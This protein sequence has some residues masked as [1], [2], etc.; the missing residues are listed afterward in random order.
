MADSADIESSANSTAE[1]PADG[2]R[3]RGYAA[4][5]RRPPARASRLVAMMKLLLPATALAIV[6]L[7]VAWPQ[8]L[9]SQ[10]EFRVGEGGVAGAHI[11]GLVM[12]NPRYVGVDDQRR[13]YQV[14]AGTASQQAK[15]DT[16]I[17]LDGPKA[18]MLVSDDSWVALT[19][20][21]GI[22][23]RSIEVVELT[24][25][26]TIF[27]DRGYQFQS[28][29]ARIDLRAGTAS[30]DRPVTGHG[31]AGEISGQGFRIFD[32]GARI[33][34]TGRST[35]ILNGVAGKRS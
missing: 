16:H 7:T 31:E 8:L 30:G 24:G 18:D 32:R 13:P 22:Y 11:D 34:F 4:I 10:G 12:D 33:I 2:R 17:Y 1:S 6:G 3:R 28:D 26:V 25:G 23:D 29:S 5:R 20:E 19:A 27:Y 35:A 21:S 9:P 15:S 14:S